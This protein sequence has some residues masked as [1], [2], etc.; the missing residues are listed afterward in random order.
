MYPQNEQNRSSTL[1]PLHLNPMDIL[2]SVFT[3][4]FYL[5]N[6]FKVPSN[7]CNDFIF[8]SLNVLPQLSIT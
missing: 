2:R 7:S 3:R 4:V 6:F 5:K 8:D 1:R